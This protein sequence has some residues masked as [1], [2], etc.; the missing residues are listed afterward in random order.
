MKNLYLFL[1]EELKNW[2]LGYEW[3]RANELVVSLGEGFGGG[4]LLWKESFVEGWSVV[5]DPVVSGVRFF[6]AGPGLMLVYVPAG[7]R[8]VTFTMPLTNIRIVG[9]IVS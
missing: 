4:C 1:A 5:V 8:Q 9:I 2:A 3:V 6:Y 7:V